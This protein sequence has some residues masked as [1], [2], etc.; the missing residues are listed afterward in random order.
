[1]I[2]IS[3]N[4]LPTVLTCWTTSLLEV[5]YLDQGQQTALRAGNAVFLGQ[6]GAGSRSLTK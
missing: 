3:I 5:G 4:E 6:N 1:M 2:D